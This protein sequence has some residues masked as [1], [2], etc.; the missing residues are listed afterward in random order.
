MTFIQFQKQIT[1]LGSILMQQ[2]MT[3]ILNVVLKLNIILVK[4]QTR[5]IGPM[6]ICYSLIQQMLLQDL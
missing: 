2:E 6:E 1:R 5:E 3:L 4:S